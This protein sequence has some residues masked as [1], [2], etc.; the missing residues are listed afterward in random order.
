MNQIRNILSFLLVAGAACVH[1]QQPIVKINGGSTASGCD[2]TAAPGAPIF[3]LDATG[4]VLVNGTLNPVGCGAATG[5]NNTPTFGL[6]PPA[7]ALLINGGPAASVSSQD[8]ATSAPF[9]YQAYYADSCSVGTPTTTGT[10]PAVTASNGACT[11][12]GASKSCAPTNATLSIPTSAAM[13]TNLQCTYTV[14]ATC[15]PNSVTSTAILTVNK[16]EGG[17]PVC[18]ALVPVK[19]ATGANWTQVTGS[20][21]VKYG[22][23]STAMKTATD[24]VSVWS[25]PGSSVAWPGNSGLSTRPTASVNFY[26]AEKFLVP[27]DGSV[28]GHPNWSWSGSGINSNASFTISQCPGD[29]GQ[30]GSVLTTGCKVGQGQ[31]ASGLTALVSD[32]QVGSFCSLKP[33]KNYYLN[34]LPMAPLPV[35]NVSTSSCSGTCTPWLGQTH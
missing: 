28:T 24:Y 20:T 23:G 19:T 17:D 35:S 31:S 11:G 14:K 18:S 26:F 30:A 2:V 21:S 8:T 13:G 15:L 12:S 16:P 5:G 33:G 25:Y 29:F 3:Q 4:N 22:D 27:S 9:T 10:C 34:I 32:T 1:A 7:S 6:S